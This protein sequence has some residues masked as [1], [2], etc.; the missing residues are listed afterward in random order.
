MLVGPC[1][2]PPSH[3]FLF[4]LNPGQCGITINSDWNEPLDPKNPKDVA[5]A[6]KLLQCKFGWFANPI[7]GTTGDYPEVMRTQL[8]QK[9]KE[10]GLPESPLPQFTAEERKLLKGK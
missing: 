9:A 3:R 10:M 8:E 1:G 5:G 2:N 4:I 7:F 6:E